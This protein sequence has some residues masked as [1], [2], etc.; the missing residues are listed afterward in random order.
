MNS[1][2]VYLLGGGIW[3][4]LYGVWCGGGREGGWVGFGVVISLS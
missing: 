4:V 3:V 2:G 1:V